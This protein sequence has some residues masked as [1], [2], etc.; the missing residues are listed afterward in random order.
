MSVEPGYLDI[1][2]YQG[3]NY[4]IDITVQDES[5]AYRDFSGESPTSLVHMDIRTHEQEVTPTATWESPVEI[6]LYEGSATNP[7]IKIDVGANA[8]TAIPAGVYV[9]DMELTRDGVVER[10][11]EGILTVH[12][13][14]TRSNDTIAS[15]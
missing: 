5:G 3:S 6:K 7:N 10:L 2:I 4:A 8:T 15:Y 11:L 1:H 13:S 14:I 12:R 9:Y